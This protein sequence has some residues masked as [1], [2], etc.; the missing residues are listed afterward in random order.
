MLGEL[1]EIKQRRKKLNLSQSGLARLAGVSQSLIAKLEAGKI[2]PTY[3]KTK[4]IFE[5]LDAMHQKDEQKAAD[6]MN[7]KIIFVSPKDSVKDTIQKMKRHEI[8]QLPVI[9]E[10]TAVGC[11]SET[12]L[13]DALLA[14]RHYSSVQDVMGDAPPVVPKE[15][16]LTVVM[17][18]LRHFPM[19]LISSNGKLVGV[20]TKQD[21]LKMMLG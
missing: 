18:I 16:S 21:M 9:D 15:A 19:V 17:G 2:D 14:G 4:K 1:S 12:T 5:A 10:K 20:I 11:V 6:V 7:N 13:L 8:S 3:T